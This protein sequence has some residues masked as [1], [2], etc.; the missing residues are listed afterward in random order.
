MLI[1]ANRCLK[2]GHEWVTQS[3]DDTLPKVP[4]MCPN[5]KKRFSNPSVGNPPLWATEPAEYW[6][7]QF[8]SY[9]EVRNRLKELNKAE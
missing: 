2:C 7:E 8:E 5:C 9:P 4:K 1:R 6:R 3:K